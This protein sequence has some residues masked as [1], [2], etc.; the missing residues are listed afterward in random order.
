MKNTIVIGETSSGFLKYLGTL[1]TFDILL[2]NAD[3]I[4]S[5]DFN[6][7]CDVLVK[8]KETGN[9]KQWTNDGFKPIKLTG[10]TIHLKQPISFTISE[11]DTG[12]LY[13][14]TVEIV[15]IHEIE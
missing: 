8:D 13:S 11:Y 4:E 2:E 1:A 6:I 7:F 10:R 5:T 15:D 14:N 3:D 12:V 9:V